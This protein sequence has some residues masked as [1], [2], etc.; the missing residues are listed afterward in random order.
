MSSLAYV[1]FP[2]RYINLQNGYAVFST[3]DPRSSD[4]LPVDEK[5]TSLEVISTS[6]GRLKVNKKG[7]V[8]NEDGDPIAKLSEGDMIALAAFMASRNP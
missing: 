3:E 6:I 1:F 8:V 5:F 7:E 2:D 4:H